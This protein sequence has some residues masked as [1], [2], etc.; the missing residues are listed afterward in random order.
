MYSVGYLDFIGGFPFGHSRIKDCQLPDLSRLPRPSSKN[1]GMP[2]HP[3]YALMCFDHPG[4]Q[5]PRRSDNRCLGVRNNCISYADNVGNTRGPLR[6]SPK[7]P[8]PCFAYGRRIH[9]RVSLVEDRRSSFRGAPFGDEG[10]G[11]GPTLGKH[12]V[13]SRTGF[14]SPARV[15]LSSRMAGLTTI[16]GIVHLLRRADS[17]EVAASNVAV[18][19]ETCGCCQYLN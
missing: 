4:R 5:F 3:S 16:P 18:G 7:G 9:M 11:R 12:F 10:N 1:P 13:R 2:S 19:G 8:P 6:P 17:G 15:G 14:D